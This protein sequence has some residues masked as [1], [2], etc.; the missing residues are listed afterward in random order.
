[1]NW[2]PLK[3]VYISPSPQTGTLPSPESSVK[4][5]PGGL[6]SQINRQQ[7]D[8]SDLLAP[9]AKTQI[10][11]PRTINLNTKSVDY[12]IFSE[13]WILNKVNDQQNKVL[14]MIRVYISSIV[15]FTAGQNNNISFSS[16]NTKNMYKR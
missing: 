10:L 9:R 2:A 6:R 12:K 7:T 3:C 5:P 4:S 8:N 15:Q 16:F 14:P 13:L 1:M 11:L